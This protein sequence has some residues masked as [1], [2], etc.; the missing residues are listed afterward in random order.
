MGLRT[1]KIIPVYSDRVNLLPLKTGG[2]FVKLF[3]ELLLKKLFQDNL[4]SEFEQVFY[5]HPYE[6]KNG[7]DWLLSLQDMSS[8]PLKDRL[9]W[10]LRQAQWLRIGNNSLSKKIENLLGDQRFSGT[11]IE[12]IS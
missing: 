9:Y 11:L 3:P 8:L 6:F 5:F 12:H 2:S 7:K 10:R 1:L 4:E